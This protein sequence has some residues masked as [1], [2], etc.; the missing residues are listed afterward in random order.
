[1]ELKV[2]FL[3]FEKKQPYLTNEKEIDNLICQN[4]KWIKF[5]KG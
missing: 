2:A 1:V 4:L 5:M 3:R